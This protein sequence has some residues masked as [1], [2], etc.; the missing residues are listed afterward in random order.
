MPQSST[1]GAL[2]RVPQVLHT[3]EL[4]VPVEA[5]M[6]GLGV[7]VVQIF[8]QELQDDKDVCSGY[9]ESVDSQTLKG[10]FKWFDQCFNVEFE[11]TTR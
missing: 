9:K 7:M 3:D 5:V 1:F 6:L 11:C 10:L 4:V 8:S 2:P